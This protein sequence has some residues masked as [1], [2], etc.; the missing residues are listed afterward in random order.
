M[1]KNPYPLEPLI[2][3]PVTWETSVICTQ[4]YIAHIREYP[5]PWDCSDY[6]MV[7]WLKLLSSQ[8]IDRKA[9]DEK[10]KVS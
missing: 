10:S 2:I 5:N 1:A 6:E 4:V 3:A 7:K 8:T 9:Q